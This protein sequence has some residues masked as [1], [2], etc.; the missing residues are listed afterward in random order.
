MNVWIGEGRIVRDLDLQ[1]SKSGTEFCKFSVAVNRKPDK[2]GEKK[3]DF[4]DCTVFGKIAA[5]LCKYFKKG[6]GV[7]VRGRLESDTYEAKDGTKRTRWSVTVDEIDFPQGKSNRD[8][9]PADANTFTDPSTADANT[10]TDLSGVDI[11]F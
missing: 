5:F 4:I 6:D 8:S 10:F 9:A 3:A 1:T 2:N 11:P 7:L